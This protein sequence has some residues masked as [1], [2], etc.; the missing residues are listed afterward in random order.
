MIVVGLV[1]D[2]NYAIV[3]QMLFRGPNTGGYH[4]KQ[5][6]H[7]LIIFSYYT[8]KT[9]GPLRLKDV[10]FPPLGNKREGKK[11]SLKKS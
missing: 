8:F 7:G 10:S 2:L 5:S 11:S 4:D 9:N 3:Y 1:T 6:R